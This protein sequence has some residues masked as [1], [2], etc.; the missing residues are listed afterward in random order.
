MKL[1]LFTDMHG[2]S[3]TLEKLK[4]KIKTHKPDLAVCAGDITFFGS[5]LRGMLRRINAFKIPVI[6]VHGNHEHEGEFR[7]LVKNYPWIK[8]VH[9]RSYRY[10]DI[11][12]IG[13]GGGGFAVID[14]E[15]EECQKKLSDILK[16]NKQRKQ[17]MVVHGPP[18][19]T[20]L[21]ELYG[22]HVGNKTLRNFISKHKLNYVIC[23][24]I[25]ENFRREDKI[26]KTTIINPGPT[27][28]I[29]KI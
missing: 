8:Y 18:H 29:I 7:K 11:V 17:I 15:L 4:K 19:K 27:G 22:H 6:M 2:S 12:F 16:K 26:K 23:G 25:H 24:H 9:K 13:Y 5:G 20:T 3:S 10:K 1:L 21:D 28:K 14:R